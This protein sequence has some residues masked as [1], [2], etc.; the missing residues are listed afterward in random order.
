M[1]GVSKSRNRH[2]AIGRIDSGR[3]GAHAVHQL[4]LSQI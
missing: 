4:L 3:N 2:A 1:K